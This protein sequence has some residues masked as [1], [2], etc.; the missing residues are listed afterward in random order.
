MPADVTSPL[1]PE[2]LRGF[3][4]R[5]IGPKDAA[6][7]V[8]RARGELTGDELRA[9]TEMVTQTRLLSWADCIRYVQLRRPLA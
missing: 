6:E 3:A 8:S 2:V 5:G 1:D 7:L 4:A 9:A